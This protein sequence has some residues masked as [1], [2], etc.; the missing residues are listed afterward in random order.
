M[1]EALMEWPT[2]IKANPLIF[3]AATLALP[4]VNE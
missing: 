2:R 3:E 4:K 1:D